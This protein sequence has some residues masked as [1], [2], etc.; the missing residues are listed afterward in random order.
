MR[1]Q[2]LNLLRYGKFTERVL[3]LPAAP[4]DF[5]FIVGANEAGKSTTRSAILDLL[6]GIETRSSYDF[7]H[8]KA[9]MRLGATLQHAGQALD[10]VRIKARLKTLQTPSGT[11]LP[12]TA[13]ASFLGGTDRTFFDQMFGL[14]HG[15]LQAGGNAILSAHNDV[16]QILF[17]SAAGIASLGSVRDQLAQEADSLWARRR[18]NDR[19]YYKAS[20]ELADAEVALKA[21]TVRTKDWVDAQERVKTLDERRQA[22]AQQ[23]RA[24]EAERLQLE[25][26]RRVAPALA[27]WRE[28]QAT[29]AGLAAA[30]LLPEHA[31]RQ[32]AD[33]ELALAAA[34]RDQQLLAAQM[35]ALVAQQAAVV[36]D[37]ALLQHQAEI[38]ALA[39]RRQ[40]VLNHERDIHRRRLELAA[41]GQ[42]L[43]TLLRQLGWP[44]GAL[45][46]E[47]LPTTPLPSLPA[48]AALAALA[49]Q[50]A[51][52]QQAEEAANG[53][54]GRQDRR[55]P[56]AAACRSTPARRRRALADRCRRCC[57]PRWPRPVRWVMRRRPWRVT[58]PRSPV[59]NASWPPPR[60]HSAPGRPTPPRCAS[61]CCRRRKTWRAAC[62]PR[63][64]RKR[65]ARRWP[66]SSPNWPAPCRHRPCWSRNTA[67]PTSPSPAQL[68]Q[69]RAERDALW[70]AVKSGAQTVHAAAADM[71]HRIAH[72]DQVADQRHDKAQAE[73]EL[74]ARQDVL[75]RL[76]QQADDTAARSVAAQAGLAAQQA[77]WDASALAAGLA[78]LALQDAPAWCAALAQALRAADALADALHALQATQQ[79]VDSS[80]AA[81]RAALAA[82]GS[83][84]GATSSS[85]GL[86]TTL[87]LAALDWPAL[88]LLAGD[89]VDGA[90][91]AHARLQELHKQLD[92]AELARARLQDKASA[93]QSATAA[94]QTA[95]GAAVTAA[96]LPA[97]TGVA[98]A[99]AAL[100]VMGQI[101]TLLREMQEIRHARIDTMQ[102][103]LRDFE[104]DVARVLALAAPALVAHSAADATL[105]LAALLA[106][107]QG[108]S[109]RGRPSA[110]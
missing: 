47:G 22:L 31:A 109:A 76:Q 3:D 67:T 102:R 34:G 57:A 32:L 90:T 60:R 62:R 18:A 65:L 95:W 2:Q 55:M 33:T 49:R 103:D 85:P 5:H 35:Q 108:R 64:T 48:R 40:Q 42:H 61:V 86:A 15:R 83:V 13:L 100:G 36:V 25:R 58:P 24:L 96:G 87:D 75:E 17:Q 38:Q 101:D 12:E 71:D 23:V 70:S 53:A 74:Q 9:D 79:R 27:Q 80:A 11:A 106:R 107:A 93:A 72:A 88:L 56:G 4:R 78:G 68:Q 39:E 7:V 91:A 94:W 54:A 92:L 19:A 29:L 73:S 66:T 97:D 16:G 26:V 46:A 14:D 59:A 20:D 6:Y 82:A 10:F 51:V 77:D 98:A 81:L 89:A 50:H 41:H 69:A 45:D 21:A 105:E 43:Q 1:I 44:E 104:Q 52:L 8:A 30:P 84:Q 37:P 110:A 28:H 63:P 99:E